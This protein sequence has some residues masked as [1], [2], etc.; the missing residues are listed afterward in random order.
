MK[1]NKIVYFYPLLRK[2]DKHS[3]FLILVIGNLKLC[4]Q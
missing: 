4:S 2:K 3:E 1:G